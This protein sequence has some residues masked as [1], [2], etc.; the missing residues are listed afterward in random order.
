MPSFESEHRKNIDQQDLSGPEAGRGKNAANIDKNDMRIKKFKSDKSNKPRDLKSICY[1]LLQKIDE[2]ASKQNIAGEATSDE[3]PSKQIKSEPKRNSGLNHA[4]V[5]SKKRADNDLRK[6]IGSAMPL[7]NQFSN[8]NLPNNKVEDG[9]ASAASSSTPDESSSGLDRPILDLGSFGDPLAV[10]MESFF[11]FNFEISESL[12]DLVAEFELK[13]RVNQWN[14]WGEDES[15]V[16]ES[17][18]D[19]DD[20]PYNPIATKNPK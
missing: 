7:R 11:E 19:S 5:P 14:E 12:D 18:F 8:Q 4:P 16:V 17:E 9:D 6:D 15:I 3:E 20:E 2:V 1:R 13:N 10:S